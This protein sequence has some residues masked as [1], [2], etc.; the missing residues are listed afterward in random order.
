MNN[1]KQMKD[2]WAK[3]LNNKEW[4]FFTTMTTNYHLSKASARRAAERFYN[5][6]ERIFG[7]CRIF[8]VAERHKDKGGYHLHSLIKLPNSKANG[9]KV[10]NESWKTVSKGN[11]N[12]I[13][14]QKYNSKLGANH[15]LTKDIL[16]NTT[17]YDFSFSP[18]NN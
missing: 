8:W 4:D 18:R 13:D 12:R 2:E 15:Y 14:T 16:K 10:I 7:E 9:F 6:L 5:R 17:D 1:T 11:D 3:W